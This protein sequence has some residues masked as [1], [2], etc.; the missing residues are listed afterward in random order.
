[1]LKPGMTVGY[2]PVINDFFEKHGN[3]TTLD[4]NNAKAMLQ[5]IFND[6]SKK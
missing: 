5:S 2:N 4:Q 6:F 3:V 1:M